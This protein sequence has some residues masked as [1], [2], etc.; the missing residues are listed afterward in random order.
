MKNLQRKK[1]NN[2]NGV[3]TNSINVDMIYSQMKSAIERRNEMQERQD[4]IWA[5]IKRTNSSGHAELCDID[6]RIGQATHRVNELI[7]KL[8]Q[9]RKA[10]RA[11]NLAYVY[12]TKEITRNEKIVTH[13]EKLIRD[14]EYGRTRLINSHGVTHTNTT[15]LR[16]Y[17]AKKKEQIHKLER[18]RRHVS[19][20]RVG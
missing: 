17:V 5:R 20:Y 7:S 3:R 10:H 15:N 6:N 4:K 13:Q 12:L 14:V 11:M 9:C 16:K 19:Y 18:W 1:T 8:C 2:Q